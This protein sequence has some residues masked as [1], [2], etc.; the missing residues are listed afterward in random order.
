MREKCCWEAT[1]GRLTLRKGNLNEEVVLSWS[2]ML[3]QLIRLI[4]VLIWKKVL[5][6][7]SDQKIFSRQ[8]YKTDN[9]EAE[10]AM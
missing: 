5:N 7:L 3:H 6:G 10:N 9:G 2:N 4:I 8:L 1:E